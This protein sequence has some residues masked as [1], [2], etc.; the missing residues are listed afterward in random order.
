MKLVTYPLVKN[1]ITEIGIAI[2]IIIRSACRKVSLNFSLL[3]SPSS[4]VNFGKKAVEI[5]TP[6]KLIG[7][8]C[9]FV[10]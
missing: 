10:A 6:I 2:Q 3:P 4:S 1:A 7:I 9:R 5:A 8:V